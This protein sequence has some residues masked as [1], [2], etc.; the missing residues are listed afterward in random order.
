VVP[1]EGRNRCFQGVGDN[2]PWRKR[3]KL[4]TMLDSATHSELRQRLA[5]GGRALGDAVL[6]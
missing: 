4:R 5:E 3:E 6:S 1:I 2:R